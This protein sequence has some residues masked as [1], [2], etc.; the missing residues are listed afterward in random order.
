[1]YEYVLTWHGME[2][3]L[4]FRADN[5][6]AAKRIQTKHK[7]RTGLRTKLYAKVG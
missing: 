5:A 7:E 1:M 3:L 4:E 2:V 6:D